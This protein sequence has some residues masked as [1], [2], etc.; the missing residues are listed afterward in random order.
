M[1][2][3]L[4]ASVL[5]GVGAPARAE[6]PTV[7][8]AH[9]DWLRRELTRPDGTTAVY[10]QIYATPVQPGRRDGPYK[11]VDAGG[12]GVGCVD[13]VARAAIVY[14]QAAERTGDEAAW[15]HAR[16]A[17]TFVRSM[18][19]SDGTYYNFVDASGRI[20]MTGPTSRKGLTWWTARALWA[21]AVGAHAFARRDP[22]F[23]AD[24]RRDAA[25]T[26]QT[27]LWDT[28]PRYHRYARWGPVRIPA[29]FMGGAPDVTSVA[30]LGLATLQSDSPSPVVKLLLRR[31]SEAIATYYAG[32]AGHFPYHAHLPSRAVTSWHAYGAH[33]LHA[34]ALAGN[35][36]HEPRLV[37]EARHEAENFTVHLLINGGPL[38]GFSPAPRPFPQI[39]YN[40][41]PEVSGLLALYDATGDA[42][43][44][45]LAGLFASWLLGNNLA[46]RPMYDP[47][48]GRVWDGIDAAHDLDPD[49][50]LGQASADAGA[51]STVEGLLALQAL[52]AHATFWPYALATS[53]ATGPEALGLPRVLEGESAKGVSSVMLASG[54]DWSGDRYAV[55]QPGEAI[56]WTFHSS[57]DFL[58]VPIFAR[59]RHLEGERAVLRVSASGVTQACRPVFPQAGATAATIEA[60]QLP[61]PFPLSPGDD[62]VA[63][64]AAT[65]RQALKLDGLVLQPAV[66]ARWFRQGD[67][68][69]AV[70]R[71]YTGRPRVFGWP[72]AGKTRASD[73]Y[74]LAPHAWLL[75]ERRRAR[76]R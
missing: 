22:V 64:Y 63:S 51:E 8:L 34:L 20:N 69:L 5:A 3:V 67:E 46:Q 47:A 49:G 13:D 1:T 23:A 16:E 40:V 58:F 41:E 9:L 56:R 76:E 37:A 10:W 35:V 30:V 2:A 42:R 21:T 55:L 72:E 45:K 44:G 32:D 66:Q 14:A 70:V 28:V 36:L 50:P 68:E 19:A 7:N 53:P 18:E 38:W 61:H 74:G 71:N 17:L 6:G 62:V 59:D 57:G 54:A 48:T 31:Y 12:E 60:G 75:V 43:F 39:A 25:K 73:R 4:A 29:W 15:T 65:A 11:Y 27:L 26:V 52:Q 24:L 33:M